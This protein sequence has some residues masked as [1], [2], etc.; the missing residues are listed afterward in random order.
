VKAPTK[1]AVFHKP[2]PGSLR[3]R[4]GLGVLL[5]V[6]MVSVVYLPAVRGAFLWDDDQNVTDNYLLRDVEGL[7]RIWLE[8]KALYQY[9]PV[10]FSVFWVGYH[11][12]GLDPTGYH[13]VNLLIH[14]ANAVVVWG[15]FRKLKIPGAW[16][17]AAIFA[18]HP[19]HVESV[20]WITELKNVLSSFFF[21]CSVWAY[22][23]FGLGAKGS[24]KIYLLAFVL[25][26]GALG[27]K[28]VTAVMPCVMVLLLWWKKDSL[29]RRDVLLLVP[30]L[31][32]GLGMGW[33]ASYLETRPIQT[34]ST[35]FLLQRSLIAGQSVWFYLGKLAVPVNLCP[36]YSKWQLT[37]PIWVQYFSLVGVLAATRLLWGFRRR[38]GKWWLVGCLYFVGTLVPVLGFFDYL[39]MNQSFVADRYLYLPSLAPIGIFAGVSAFFLRRYSRGWG[40]GLGLAV[41]LV[42]G[43]LTWRQSHIYKDLETFARLGLKPNSLSGKMFLAACMADKGKTAEGISLLRMVVKEHPEFHL[44]RNNL[45][46]ELATTDNA[47]LR[48]GPEAVRLAQEAVAATGGIC[49]G[50]L[51]TLGA[52]YA[53]AGRFADAVKVTQKSLDLATSSGQSYRL[54]KI[55]ESLERY[56]SGRPYRQQLNFPNTQRAGGAGTR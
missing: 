27:S 49:L 13:V 24:W 37:T 18:V 53:E 46:W 45:A 50:Y 26:V 20:A 4:V 2:E 25:F 10:V 1:K 44:A 55:R 16:F 31:V 17:G 8:P 32:S 56:R 21:L 19:V 7:K 23:R 54:P 52:A 28:P 3:V 30:F 41:L 36:I 9:Y 43:I 11:L 34:A 35:L 51:D 42:L 38:I 5:L 47:A 22:L 29:G 6:A 33:V 15:I 12:W 14:A 40:Y 39:F 48:N